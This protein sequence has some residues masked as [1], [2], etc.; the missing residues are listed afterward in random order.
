MKPPANMLVL[1]A[2][3]NFLRHTL[4]H[5][6]VCELKSF[7]QDVIVSLVA[8]GVIAIA[9]ASETID[10]GILSEASRLKELPDFGR[11]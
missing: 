8:L 7:C 4:V 11:W 2:R 6:R 10:H 1:L 3:I 5:V 9:I